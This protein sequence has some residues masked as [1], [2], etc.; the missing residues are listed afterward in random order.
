MKKEYRRVVSGSITD[1]IILI[2]VALVAYGVFAICLA[3]GK[4]K[5]PVLPYIIL[6]GV[7][8][9][10]SLPLIAAGIFI[11]VDASKKKK[12]LAKGTKRQCQI[13]ELFAR[14][15]RY[16]DT[17]HMVATYKGDSGRYYKVKFPLSKEQY[18]TLIKGYVFDCIVYKEDCTFE[19]SDVSQAHR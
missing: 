10:I 3:L 8:P 13:L 5:D 12:I 1:G 9:A 18:Y 15:V 7:A 14:H 4:E 11:I 16:V 19:S 2:V 17:Y 6:C